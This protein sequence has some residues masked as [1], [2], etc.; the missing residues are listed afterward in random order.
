MP[1]QTLSLALDP[2]VRRGSASARLVIFDFLALFTFL[3]VVNYLLAPDDLGWFA[4]NPTPFLIIPAFLGMRHGV[5]VGLSAGLLTA[6]LLLV[7]R[8]A[9]GDGTSLALHGYALLTYPVF[10]TLIGLGAGR[11]S[12]RRAHLEVESEHL[13]TEN[14]RLYAERELL[15]LSRQNLQQRLGIYGVDSA[16]LDEGLQELAESPAELAPSH[17]LGILERITQ[18]RCAALYAVSPGSRPHLER[19]ASLGDFSRFPGSLRAGDHPI[20]EEALSRKS[21]LIQKTLREATPS[22]TSGYLAAYPI[23]TTDGSVSCVLIVEDLPLKNFNPHTFDVMKAI[24]DW[25]KFTLAA[26]PPHQPRPGSVSQLKFY[27][28]MEAAV[29]IHA[30]QAVPSILVRIPFDCAEEIEPTDSFR[31]LLEKLPRATVLSNSYEEGR[32]FLLFLL[33]AIPDPAVRDDLRD[34]FHV[35][36]KDLGLGRGKAPHFVMTAPGETPQQLWGKLVA[37]SEQDVPTSTRR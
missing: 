16:A 34:L 3:E 35:F 24:C 27:S 11:L 25:M 7:T 22:R 10:G 21:F 8:H 31:D 4:A 15:M 17:L 9:L 5:G 23:N 33:P 19:V 6:V 2:A 37:V 26:A 20:V 14:N 30:E 28:A 12:R 29:G 1:A 18:V 13:E 36:V 32:R